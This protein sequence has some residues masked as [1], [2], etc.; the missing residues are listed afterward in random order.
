MLVEALRRP[1]ALP[2]IQPQGMLGGLADPQL[3]R[4][5]GAM[6]ADVQHAWTVGELASLAC[7]SRSVFSRRFGEA[8]GTAPIDYLLNWRMALAKDR[9]IAGEQ[10]IADIAASIGYQSA[11]AFNTAF[12][13]IVGCPPARF[14]AHSHRVSRD[15]V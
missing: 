15:P 9:L 13:R 5:L 4:A 1:T 6:H 2:G 11:S 12:S 8:I 14:A 7:L 3:A 10:S